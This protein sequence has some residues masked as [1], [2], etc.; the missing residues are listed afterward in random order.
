MK[1][2]GILTSGGDCAGLNAVIRAA[3]EAAVN[4]GWE[5]V[6]LRNGHIGLLASPP[7]VITLTADSVRGDLLRAGGTI[8]GTT[9]KDSP[10]AFPDADG[11][12]RDRSADVLA[13]LKGLG[14]EAIIII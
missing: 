2:I 14:I 5:V 10:F 6:G 11:T 12:K 7:D 8:L 13:A 1:K 9:T 4:R 3:T